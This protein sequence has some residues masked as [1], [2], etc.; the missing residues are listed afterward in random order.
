MASIIE[1]MTRVLT[2]FLLEKKKKISKTPFF[3]YLVNSH[4]YTHTSFKK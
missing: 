3:L 1:S 4:M 2:D